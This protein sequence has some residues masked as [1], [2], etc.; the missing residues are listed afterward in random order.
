MSGYGVLELFLQFKFRI[1]KTSVKIAAGTE[2][3]I[4]GWG[5]T[6]FPG[7]GFSEVLQCVEVNY[8]SKRGT[9]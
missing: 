2:M 3:T 1:N 5:E 9:E 7:N 4:C 6:K 8:I